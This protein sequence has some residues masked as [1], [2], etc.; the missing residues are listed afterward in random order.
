MANAA[1]LINNIHSS[2]LAVGDKFATTPVYE[3]FAMYAAHQGATSV[4]A[5][6][7]APELPRRQKRPL[8]ALAG[9]ASLNGSQLVLTVVNPDISNAQETAINVRGR[10]IDATEATVLTASDIHAHNTFE[11]P[12]AV[13]SSTKPV[14]TGPQLTFQFPP[15][16]VTKLVIQTSS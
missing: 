2:F 16:S 11:E 1:Q 13:R 10:K 15:A 9:S 4:R 7:N 12:N 5:I 3:V 8:P 14:P 6:F